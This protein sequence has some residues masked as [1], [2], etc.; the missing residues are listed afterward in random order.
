M[1]QTETTATDP[2][3]RRTHAIAVIAAL[4]Q[5]IAGLCWNSL[6]SMGFSRG[7]WL[8]DR[9]VDMGQ[10]IAVKLI[11]G[12]IDGYKGELPALDQCTG[13]NPAC[14]PILGW[15]GT[16]C[17]N[18][19]IDA[20][21]RE[22]W[23]A[24]VSIDA[25]EKGPMGP[26]GKRKRAKPAESRATAGACRVM[27]QRIPNPEEALIRKEEAAILRTLANALPEAQRAAF[28]ALRDCAADDIGAAA[29]ACGMTYQAFTAAKHKLGRNLAAQIERLYR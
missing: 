20:A 21:R 24:E 2:S 27:S 18:A 15:L 8:T 26:D 7:T 19:C 5:S 28:Y 12:A 10:S 22:D 6:V 4:M 17:R 3:A 11:E 1:T 9:A 13:R 16:V 25:T 23:G 29:H 14:R